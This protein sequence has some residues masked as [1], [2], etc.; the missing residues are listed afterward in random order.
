MKPLSLDL[1]Q[2]VAQALETGAAQTSIAQRFAVSLASVERISRKQRNQES[3]KPK[4]STGRKPRVA[5]EQQHAFE[6]LA[7]SRTNWT[8]QTLA[9]AWQEQGGK[10][11]SQATTSRTLRRSGFSFKKRAVSPANATKPS[12]KPSASR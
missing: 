10:A 7:A 5:P 6:Q 8:L 9:Q 3:L 1:R 11:L 12:A 2:R 4:V